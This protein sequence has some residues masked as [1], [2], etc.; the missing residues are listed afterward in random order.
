MKRSLLFGIILAGCSVVCFGAPKP[1]TNP[2]PQAYT[3]NL[4]LV[5]QPQAD[6]YANL[7]YGIRLNVQ[8]VRANQRIIQVYDASATSIPA[9]STNPSLMS[10]IPESFRRYMRTM[11]FN[12]DA[13]IATDYMMQIDVKEFHSDYLSGLGWN[14]TVMMDL[15]VLDHDRTVVYPAVEIGGRATIN[16][17]AY[18]QDAANM[19]LNNAYANALADVDWDRIAFILHKQKKDEAAEQMQAQK[20]KLVKAP[21]HWE[22]QSRPQGADIYWRVISSTE[23]VKNQNA[24]YLETTPYETTE[25]FDIKGLTYENSEDVQIEIRCEKEGY[26]TQKKRFSLNSILDEKELSVFFK[27]VKLED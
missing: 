18:S 24:K 23:E 5:A 26:A 8:D 3:F 10:F 9:S 13:D 2:Q 15:K 14:G 21:I 19:A 12:L 17:S 20:A 16:G 4:A 6:K 1:K 25:P 7:A 11:G 27:L 22:I